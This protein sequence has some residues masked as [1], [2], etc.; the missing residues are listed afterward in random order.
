M[1]TVKKI[2]CFNFVIVCVAAVFIV[3]G[4]LF[5]SAEIIHTPEGV[6]VTHY[7]PQFDL[8]GHIDRIDERGIVVHDRYFSFARQTKFMTP[9][10]PSAPLRNFKDGDEVGLVFN[11]QRQ[12]KTL[13]IIYRGK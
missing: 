1:Y 13:C 12:V 9:Q 10:Q 6:I 8:V 2:I 11:D 3:G 5:T 4:A 7:P